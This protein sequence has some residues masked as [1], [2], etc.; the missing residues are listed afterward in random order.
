MQVTVVIPNF[1]GWEILPETL[2]GLLRVLS[3]SSLRVDVVVV[4]DAST[5]DSRDLVGERYPEVRL[6]RSPVN[7]GFGPTCNL[8]VRASSSP[9]VYFLN[10][11]VTVQT[12]FLEPLLEQMRDENRFSV[13]SLNLHEDGRVQQPMQVTPELRWGQIRLRTMDRDEVWRNPRLADVG[14]IYTLYGAGSSLLVRRDRFLELGGFADAFSPYYYEDADLGWRAWR[15]GWSTV[16]EPRSV[17]V[18]RNRGSIR[19]TQDPRAVS[20]IRKRNRF[21]LLWRNY[22]DPAA[23][24]RDHLAKLPFHLLASLYRS[25]VRLDASVPAGFATAWARRREV[26]AH[27]ERERSHVKRTDRE[28]FETL[29]ETRSRLLSQT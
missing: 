28:I 10:S 2:D 24:R 12:G 19:A 11:D 25:L 9:L 21:L 18:H 4:D 3:A 22:L 16:V 17:V 14:P 1:N 13:V 20:M 8:G 27:R 6:V 29:R 5:D 7:R 15:R 26:R 23:F